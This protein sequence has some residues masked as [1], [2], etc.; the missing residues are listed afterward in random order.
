MRIKAKKGKFYAYTDDRQFVGSF[1]TR[2]EAE[3]ALDTKEEA[4][5]VAH[6]EEPEDVLKETWEDDDAEEED[7]DE[8]EKKS[9]F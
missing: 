8:E 7:D 9:W 1:A 2:E 6:F 3:A 4:P 5:V